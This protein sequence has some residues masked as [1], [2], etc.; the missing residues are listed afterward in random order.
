MPLLGVMEELGELA[1]AHLK[2][3]ERV[4]GTPEEH[5]AKARDAIGDVVIFLADYC[6]AQGYDFQDCVEATWAS[7]QQRDWKANPRNG[8]RPLEALP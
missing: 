8:H 3:T 7:V 4:R 2:A 6:S 5:A 1:H